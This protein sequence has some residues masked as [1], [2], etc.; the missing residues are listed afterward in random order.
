M[1]IL[2]GNKGICFD[3]CLHLIS[4]TRR[5]QTWFVSSVIPIFPSSRLLPGNR[6]LPLQCQ[7]HLTSPVIHH[8]TQSFKRR[9]LSHCFIF[10][11]LHSL[12]DSQLNILFIKRLFNSDDQS[13]PAAYSDAH[14][15]K[16]LKGGT[17][18]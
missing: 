17:P 11:I 7:L 1:L 4:P 16:E 18:T 3:I 12:L 10:S 13:I 14:Q 9:K 15:E 5:R 6:H 8:L 2:C